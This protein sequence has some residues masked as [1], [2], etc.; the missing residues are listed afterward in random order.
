ML[1]ALTFLDMH[2]TEWTLPGCLILPCSERGKGHRS[3]C[4]G[5]LWAEKDWQRWRLFS[6][7]PLAWSYTGWTWKRWSQ[8]RKDLQTQR[9]VNAFNYI[10]KS[11]H[12]SFR[13][14]IDHFVHA[15]LSASPRSP[16]ATPCV[17]WWPCK[18][19][20]TDEVSCF[21]HY[22]HEYGMNYP[23]LSTINMHLFIFTMQSPYV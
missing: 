3:D 10:Y 4:T 6:S 11:F 5:Q 16:S 23:L 12:V 13:L 2:I 17:P 18:T 21:L 19:A 8:R 1:D 14:S 22:L 7:S 20:H 15:H 9:G